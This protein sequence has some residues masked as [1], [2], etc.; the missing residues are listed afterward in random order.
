MNEPLD[1]IDSHFPE[2]DWCQQLQRAWYEHIPL[3][4][5]AG[6]RVE[7]FTGDEFITSL[8][9]SGNQNSHQT[10]FAG[11]LFVLATLTGWGLIWLLMKKRHLSGTIVLA[12]AHIRYGAPLIGPATAIASRASCDGKLERLARGGKA[13]LRLDVGLQD[14]SQSQA[15]FE[16][17]YVVLPGPETN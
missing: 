8:P 9:A 17:T 7:G 12:D 1:S 11:S 4:E 6:I 13:R 14:E 16:G 5:K 2:S 15:S 10:L 3:S